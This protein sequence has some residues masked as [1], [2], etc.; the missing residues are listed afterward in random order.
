M[1]YSF[2]FFSSFTNAGIIA[3]ITIKNGS[4]AA[5]EIV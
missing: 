2:S 1:L 4:V 3:I 5:M